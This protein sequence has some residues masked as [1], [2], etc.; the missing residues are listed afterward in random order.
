MTLQGL[1]GPSENRVGITETA[2]VR[3]SLI[4]ARIGFANGVP[5]AEKPS[6][7]FLDRDPIHNLVHSPPRATACREPCA[8]RI[9]L[10]SL[11]QRVA[12][13]VISIHNNDNSVVIRQPRR[14]APKPLGKPAEEIVLALEG[15]N[16]E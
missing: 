9:P 3:D 5:I 14:I 15:I 13:V 16:L 1:P 7:Q 8:L 10:Q 2:L 12:I 6:F 4:D 11:L